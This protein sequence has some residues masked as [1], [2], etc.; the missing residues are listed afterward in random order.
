MHYEQKLIGG[1]LYW[2][3]RELIGGRQKSTYIGKNLPEKTIIEVSAQRLQYQGDRA[4]QKQRAEL[5]QKISQL[6]AE[7]RKI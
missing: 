5:E 1:N 7:L 6:Q 4:R 2:Y 3:R